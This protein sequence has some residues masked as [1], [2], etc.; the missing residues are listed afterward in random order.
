MKAANVF[1]YPLAIVIA[2]LMLVI[3]INE[4]LAFDEL[5]REAIKIYPEQELVCQ[6]MAAVASEI[7]TYRKSNPDSVLSDYEQTVDREDKALQLKFVMAYK[8]Y[9]SGQFA[10]MATPDEVASH[11]NSHCVGTFQQMNAGALKS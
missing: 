3:L 9:K 4:S 5:S 11:W 10:V 1:K 2:L 7:Q 8:I 6:D